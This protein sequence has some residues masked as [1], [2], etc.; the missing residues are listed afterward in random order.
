M[1]FIK[2]FEQEKNIFC[3]FQ[4]F[5]VFRG[6]EIGYNTIASHEYDTIFLCGQILI[7]LMDW[8]SKTW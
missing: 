6:S 3:C 1:I 5:D 8:H 2:F 7:W 4:N